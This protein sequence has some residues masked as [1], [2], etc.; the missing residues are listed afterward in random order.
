MRYVLQLSYAGTKYHGWQVQ[1]NAHTVQAQLNKA[2]S[3][4]AGHQV[5]T[6]GCG[7]T[8]TGV[9]AK[10]FFAQLDTETPLKKGWVYKLNNILPVDIAILALYTVPADCNVRFDADFRL[11]EYH[12]H[13][14][15]DP[16]LEGWSY[17]RYGRLDF[18]TMNTAAQKL[19]NYEHF[20]CFSK[21][22]TQVATYRCKIMRAEWVKTGHHTYI[23]YIQAD[24]FL[25]NMVR[26]IV[27]TLLEVG[28]GKMT[29]EEF[30]EVIQSKKR[31][32]AGQSVP[33]HALYLAQV[34]Y[35]FERLKWTK[36]D[37]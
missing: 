4:V 21:S 15:P 5:E 34:G 9:H 16:F 26:A 18:E 20:E 17:Y 35:D 22:R 11:Y 8:D 19:F 27:G 29:V 2:L 7:R 14:Q 10:Q 6:L 36:T 28:T 33:A 24:R 3:L 12:L 23:F 30:E 25:R 13:T 37:E 1:E 32:E 31:T